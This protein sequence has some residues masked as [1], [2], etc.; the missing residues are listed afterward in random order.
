MKALDALRVLGPIDAKSTLRDPL[1]GWMIALPL[2]LGVGV[3]FAV[4]AFATWTRS[5]FDFALEP[6]F[7]LIESYALLLTM[8]LLAGL[9]VGFLLLDERDDDTL[10]ALL[11][12]PLSLRAYLAYRITIPLVACVG[13]SLL[14]IELANVSALPWRRLVPILLVNGLGGPLLTL[15][16]ATFAENKVQGFALLKAFQAT[17]LAPVLAYFV[18]SP[19]AWAAGIVPAFWPAKAFWIAGQESAPFWSV[20]LAGALLHLG[21]LGLLLRRFDRVLHR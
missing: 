4:P 2:L 12:T 5:E 3:R 9:V 14:A 15:F 17:L 20:L 19:L 18:A 11:V 10:T 7:P 8:P 21:V 13:M 6:Y 16:L 1:L